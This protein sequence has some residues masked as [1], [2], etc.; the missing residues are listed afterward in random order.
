MLQTAGTALQLIGALVTAYGLFYAWNRIAA[1]F[2]QWR[3]GVVS[4]FAEWRE[5]ATGKHKAAADR[6]VAVRA[7]TDGMVGRPGTPEERLIRVEREVST[8]LGQ[9]GQ[10]NVPTVAAIAD[11]LAEY[12][13]WRRPSTSQTSIGHWA[14]FSSPRSAPCCA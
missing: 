10:V 8:L 11:G 9:A 12:D 4:N 2:D 3:R 14:A 6:L 7:E 1:T 5:Q 13:T